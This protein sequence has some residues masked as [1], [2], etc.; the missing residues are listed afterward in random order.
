MKKELGIRDYFTVA[1]N[2]SSQDLRKEVKFGKLA[3]SRLDMLRGRI[4]ESL[5]DVLV[6]SLAGFSSE[7][8]K[9]MAECMV[10]FYFFKE[11]TFTGCRPV[12]ATLM[13]CYLFIG[14]ELG[15]TNI[16]N[17]KFRK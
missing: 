14:M 8:Q 12:D 13:E 17:E 2:V 16:E 4:R 6:D 1:V 7:I 11:I 15:I 5:Y 9:E 10:D 3:L